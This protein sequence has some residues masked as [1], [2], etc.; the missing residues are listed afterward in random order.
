MSLRLA[1]LALGVLFLASCRGGDDV[2]VN[3]VVD[4]PDTGIAPILDR[5]DAVDVHSFAKPLDARVHHVALDLD[6]DFDA[7]RVAGTATLDLDAKDDVDEVILDTRGLTINAITAVDG[8]H[9]QFHTGKEDATLGAPLTVKMGNYRKIVIDYVSAEEST[10]LQFLNPEQTAGKRHP[11][12]LSQG[13]AIENR[14]WI[15]TQDSPGIRQTWEAKI[16]VPNPLTAVMSAATIG[17]AVPDG[18][19]HHI[20]RFEM[21]KSVPPYLIAIAVGDIT[22]EPLGLRSGVWAEPETIEAA[23]AE[24]ADTEK[25]ITEAEKLFG[26]YDWG[27]YDMIVLPPSF[28]F[29]GMENPRLTFLTPTFIAGDKSLTALIAHELAHSWSGNLATNATW[30]DFW[31]NEG[32]TVYAEQRILEAVYGEKA[33]KQAVAL[34]V[35]DLRGELPGLEPWQQALA[36][37]LEGKHPDDGFN[38]VPYDKGAAFLRTIEVAVGREKFDE[39]MRGWFSRHAFQ[40]VTSS[41]FL[42]ELREELVKGDEALEEKLRLDNWVYGE[43]LPD[44]MV[45]PDPKAFAEVDAAITAFDGGETPN[46]EAWGGWNT[47]ERLRFLGGIEGDLPPARMAALDRALGLSRTGNNEILFLWLKL[48]VANRYDA[49]LPTLEQFLTR[50]GRRKFVAPLITAL[51]EDRSWGRAKAAEFYPKVRPG[52]HPITQRGLDELGLPTGVEDDSDES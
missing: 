49:A 12:L 42:D 37:D 3:N 7:Q 38:G 11:F 4:A 48:A 32:M 27:R 45:E 35:E 28:P 25:M 9:L 36:I 23:K 5:E 15:P 10:A 31:L 34:S 50:Q 8:T 13:Q 30:A 24:L 51:A 29:G 17:D 41:M 16:R 19:T 6:V 33:Y 44:N 20:F 39:F 26:P 1:G 22:F 18:D 43:G 14:S 21:E 40:P 47:A 52:Y 2:P 46:R